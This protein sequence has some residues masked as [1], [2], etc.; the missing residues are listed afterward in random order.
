MNEEERK[1]KEALKKWKEGKDEIYDSK[2]EVYTA[3]S[4]NVPETIENT[5]TGLAFA[6]GIFVI[7]LWLSETGLLKIFDIFYLIEMWPYYFD[8]GGFE[9]IFWIMHDL[10]PLLFTL[11][12]GKCWFSLSKD[13]SADGQEVHLQ[14]SL[15]STAKALLFYFGVLVIYDLYLWFIVYNDFPDFSFF[16][17]ERIGYFWLGGLSPIFM[18][19][20]F[21][22]KII[23]AN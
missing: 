20:A 18:I 6:T 11:A 19:P 22:K 4:T 14:Q 8:W 10:M 21:R 7:S 5:R 15:E 23:H 16:F 1:R 9:A 2:T 12:I 13:I 17:M 3:L